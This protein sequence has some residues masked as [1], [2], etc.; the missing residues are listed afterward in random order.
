MSNIDDGQVLYRYADPAVFP[1]G[2]EELPISIFND[3]NLSCDWQKIQDSPDSSPHV[4]NG[5][6]MVVSITICDEF[7][8]PVNP[9]RTSQV[10]PEWKQEI[11]HDPLEMK[12]NDPFTPNPP[13]ALIRGKK[14]AAVTTGIRKNSTYQIVSYRDPKIQAV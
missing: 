2:Q 8:N 5:R 7:R 6:S 9:K 1:K 11:L 14:K 13:H 10:V 12:Q 4:A 3:P